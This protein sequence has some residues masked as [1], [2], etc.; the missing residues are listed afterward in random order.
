[1]SYI[2][3]YTSNTLLIDTDSEEVVEMYTIWDYLSHRQPV[4]DFIKYVKI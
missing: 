3:T 2:Y 4:A 1:M